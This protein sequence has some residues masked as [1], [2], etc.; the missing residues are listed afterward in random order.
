[1]LLALVPLAPL[2]C[3]AP[4]PASL[5]LVSAADPG[6]AAA[7]VERSIA[8]PVED[9]L[10]GMP[11][12]ARIASFSREGHALVAVTL[13]PGADPVAAG[14]DART[15][16]H[17]IAARLPPTAEA[18]IVSRV[19]G[20]ARP[21]L[22]L[23]ATAP[24][25]SGTDV[26]RVLEA[27]AAVLERVD[28]VAAVRV[29]GARHRLLAVDLD[30]ARLDAAGIDAASVASAIRVA[31][32]SAPGVTRAND[33]STIAAVAVRTSPAVTRVS[34]L[35]LVSETADD[36]ND[37][38]YP[39]GVDAARGALGLT[40]V[41]QAG[42]STADV[43]KA[44]LGAL[45]A[46]PETP[47]LA[48]KLVSQDSAPAPL[49]VVITE[50]SSPSAAGPAPRARA[51]EVA[52]RALAT[53][54]AIAG[55]DVALA[56]EDRPERRVI[57]DER[58]AA[59][60]GVDPAA[61]A[62]A[63]R[64]ALVGDRVSARVGVHDAPGPVRVRVTVDERLPIG[65]QLRVRATSGLVPISDIASEEVRVQPTV[66]E[67]VN[68]QRA[69]SLCATVRGRALDDVVRE[70]E[71]KLRAL[72]LPPGVTLAVE[73]DGSACNVTMTSGGAP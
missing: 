55:V 13:T 25:L 11:A 35:A 45:G 62:A 24:T 26:T 29:D 5:V 1:M 31:L 30:P 39:N 6:A 59:A 23:D 56:A 7:D 46:L 44:A 64:A 48:L 63:V 67:R 17:A 34:D 8:V 42:A 32:A 70:L 58:R 14:D 57:V 50:A 9:A 16:V 21:V 49:A 20:G 40:I 12:A 41:K 2:A 71:P 27:Y 53:M 28:G 43:Q 61:V 51:R 22:H 18:P 72:P 3:R 37:N 69:V 60:L 68:R 19:D 4:A 65:A 54:R 38:G 73:R 33:V 10:A 47:G 66:L 52:E 15:R 36:D